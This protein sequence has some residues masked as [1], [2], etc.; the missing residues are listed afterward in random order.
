MWTNAQ[1]TLLKYVFIPKAT[2]EYK[3]SNSVL[4]LPYCSRLTV[5]I[6]FA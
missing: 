5:Q 2:L 6:A 4:T 1:K 3:T